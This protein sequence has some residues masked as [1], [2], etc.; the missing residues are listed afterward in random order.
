M[1][2][3]NIIGMVL[4]ACVL[5]A[6]I[7]VF[8]WR[9]GALVGDH[10]ARLEGNKLV[11]NGRVYESSGGC[12]Y[13]E[14]RRLATT[15]DRKWQIIAVREDPSHTFV[16]VRSFLDHYLY[17]AQDY[18]IANKGTITQIA[19]NGTYISDPA[20][21]AALTQIEQEKTT[22]FVH[23]TSGI[24]VLNEQQQMKTLY[25][26]YEGCP[27][28]TEYRGY[29]GRIDGQWVITVDISTDQRNPDGSPKVYDVS[30]YRIPEEYH[31]ILED[32]LE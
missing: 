10:S 20:F 31:R 17:I 32:F 3:R 30:C 4:A 1:I 25:F 7:L 28:A 23:E 11:W 9:G 21:L 5:A 27:V 22:S 13:T 19:W 18:A 8:L 12:Q 24:F 26:A 29:L 16:V 6:L 14:G 2:K 15:E